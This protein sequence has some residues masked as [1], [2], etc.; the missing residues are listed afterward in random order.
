[1][2][3]LTEI[4]ENEEEHKEIACNNIEEEKQEVKEPRVLGQGQPG[5]PEILE[6]EEQNSLP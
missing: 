5:Q 1:M 3:Q 6:L 4:E 2:S